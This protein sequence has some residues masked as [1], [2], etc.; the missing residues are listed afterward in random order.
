MRSSYTGTLI[1]CVILSVF[2]VLFL[3]FKLRPLQNRI[4]RLNVTGN[5]NDIIENS[6]DGTRLNY[7]SRIERDMTKNC[8]SETV[9]C[10]EDDDCTAT[11]DK[12]GGQFFRCIQGR[13]KNEQY[14]DS[15]QNNVCDGRRGVIAFMVGNIDRWDFICKSIDPGIAPNDP[16]LENGMCF[17]V[18]ENTSRLV[19]DVNYFERFPD[20]KDCD[21][22]YAQY[23][24]VIPSTPGVR[25]HVKISKKF[26]D[27]LNRSYEENSL[28][29]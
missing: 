5:L 17:D 12:T 9:L 25:R 29:L 8:Q 20:Q 4:Q 23:S 13:C 2:F 26:Y 6:E 7:F 14:M 11:C 3:F 18:D 27:L 28:K 1:F 24:C 21:P 19:N 15:L 16:T 10:F 22:Q